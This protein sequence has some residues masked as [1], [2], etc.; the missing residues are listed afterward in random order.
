[1]SRVRFTNEQPANT[2][3][4]T[5]KRVRDDEKIFPPEFSR[6]QELE[7]KYANRGSLCGIKN[8]GATC[9]MNALLQ[10]IF[11]TPELRKHIVEWCFESQQCHSMNIAHQ[12]QLL[13][14]SLLHPARAVADASDLV[15]SFAM[16]EGAQYQQHDVQELNRQLLD[17]LQQ[18]IDLAKSEQIIQ[19]LYRGTFMEY[20]RCK[21]CE[22]KTVSSSTYM[23]L[24]LPIAG[25]QS[26]YDCFDAYTRPCEIEDASCDMKCN[27]KRTIEKGNKFFGYPDI[28]SLQLVRIDFNMETM[29]RDVLRDDVELPIR[30]NLTKWREDIDGT[31]YD[32]GLDEFELHSVIAHRGTA[33]HGHYYAFVRVAESPLPQSE[34]IDE[35]QTT[36]AEVGGRWIKFDDDEVKEA[37]PDE[38]EEYINPAKWKA[39]P[40]PAKPQNS[41][42]CEPQQAQ[43]AL[44]V[45][46]ETFFLFEDGENVG[47]NNNANRRVSG[48]SYYAFYRRKTLPMAQLSFP[49]LKF[50]PIV[51]RNYDDASKEI[52]AELQELEHLRATVSFGIY[53]QDN[54]KQWMSAHIDATIREVAAKAFAET[55]SD[56]ERARVAKYRLRVWNTV[57]RVLGESFNE[58]ATLRELG[59]DPKSNSFGCLALE[60]VET[61]D[62][63]AHSPWQECK[64][65]DLV[66]T[67]F[68]LNRE[69]KKFDL[70]QGNGRI[71]VQATASLSQ[72]YDKLSRVTGIDRSRLQATV[73]HKGEGFALGVRYGKDPEQDISDSA[74]VEGLHNLELTQMDEA[75]LG[76]EDPLY[77]EA[78]D[79]VPSTADELLSNLIAPTFIAESYKVDVHFRFVTAAESAHE[80]EENQ[81]AEAED[82]L[83]TTTFAKGP[84]PYKTIRM[85]KRKSLGELK[86]TLC[87]LI[88]VKQESC[89]LLV[90]Q[91]AREL[92]DLSQQINVYT[93]LKSSLTAI[94][95]EG[96]PIKADEAYAEIF[97]ATDSYVK[98]VKF[99]KRILIDQRTTVSDLQSVIFGH[100]AS[101]EPPQTSIT[102]GICHFRV[103]LMPPQRISHLG[104]PLLKPVLKDATSTTQRFDEMRFVLQRISSSENLTKQDLILRVH[105]WDA[106]A[107]DVGIGPLVEVLTTKDASV[108]SFF[109]AISQRTT[110]PV[111]E[112][113]FAK[114]RFYQLKDQVTIGNTLSWVKLEILS[115]DDKKKSLAGFPLK[116]EMDDLIL[117]RRSSERWPEGVEPTFDFS[118]QGAAVAKKK[119]GAKQEEKKKK[120]EEAGISLKAVWEYDGDAIAE[121]VPAN[122]EGS[123]EPTASEAAAP[124]PF[125]IDVEFLPTESFGVQFAELEE[126]C[127]VCFCQFEEGET[128]VVLGCHHIFHKECLAPWL[129]QRGTCPACLSRVEP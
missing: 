61:D 72:L 30:I 75:D 44:D 58:D 36:H 57:W 89:Q 97:E 43:E 28:L 119:K 69:T 46:G 73:K 5:E 41:T 118:A 11:M 121:V 92:R 90:D 22:E 107:V 74:K 62:P 55:K 70:L 91:H 128:V 99:M 122:S 34:P 20:M 98:P 115:E 8:L 80:P 27:A 12:L 120:K 17:V 95:S 13:F 76:Q 63:D 33:Y 3:K 114:A 38:I 102:D 54:T 64:E 6:R 126:Q 93:S 48:Y 9:Y 112:I 26:L 42:S 25:C 129:A 59:Y 104:L 109:E 23:D 83:A 71:T 21:T 65:P 125:G 116:M 2:Q 7:Q 56:A 85:D 127:K 87:E 32:V 101:I 84:S 39:R 113:E 31:S 37:T 96:A 67:V 15:K 29:R 78:M 124:A 108:M 45:E 47:T 14:A 40:R 106:T 10:T 19:R 117:V 110:I 100:D 49:Q 82:V 79:I 1:M 86:R 81:Q 51:Q 111:E 68:A 18:F 103:R 77:C 4:K 66:F 88:D 105:A 52:E 16:G 123:Q 50:P 53:T 35:T 94:L 24:S 60:C